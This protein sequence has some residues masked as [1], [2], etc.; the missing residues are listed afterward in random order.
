MIKGLF[1]GIFCFSAF[2]FHI[3]IFHKF[4]IRRKFFA[5]AVSFFCGI[6]IYT[7]FFLVTP[8][9]F[10]HGFL[11]V[12]FLAFLNGA[13]LHFFFFYFFIY[14]IQ[15]IDRSPA[16]RIMVEIEQAASGRLSPEQLNAVYSM[17]EKVSSELEDMVILGRL[18]KESDMYKL[19]SKGRLHSA[20]FK[21][22]RNYLKLRRS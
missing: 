2:L 5:I 10:F 18:V 20:I 1:L 6:F 4:N 14:F 16:T 11:P 21:T 9:D 22:I 19:T 13:F 15:V 7:L 8:Q 3:F 12:V 17:D